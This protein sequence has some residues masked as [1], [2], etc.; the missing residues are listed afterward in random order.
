MM[1]SFPRGKEGM[2]SLT[3]TTDSVVTSP[4]HLKI[5][6]RRLFFYGHATL[7][8]FVPTQGDERELIILLFLFLYAFYMRKELVFEY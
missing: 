3:F 4:C 5:E 6:A 7:R 8:C 1:K 2:T